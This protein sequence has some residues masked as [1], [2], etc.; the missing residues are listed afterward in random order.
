MVADLDTMELEY[1]LNLDR[2]TIGAEMLERKKK[3]ESHNDPP[4]EDPQQDPPG[5]YTP[6]PGSC[7]QESI[8]LKRIERNEGRNSEDVVPRMERY[9]RRKALSIDFN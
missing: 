1:L 8:H 3:E 9:S 4:P 2:L 6:P 5:G 7:P